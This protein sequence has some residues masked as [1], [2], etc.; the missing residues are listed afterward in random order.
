MKDHYKMIL[1]LGLGMILGSA[2]YPTVM[3]VLVITG[4]MLLAFKL[5]EE[6]TK[7]DRWKNRPRHY[8]VWEH[9]ER[10]DPDTDISVRSFTTKAG[11]KAWS[12]IKGRE[13]YVL[14]ILPRSTAEEAVIVDIMNP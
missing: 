9:C 6:S 11:A 8:D 1:M 2:L 3:A 13:G 12:S 7:N 10:T 5:K 4:L 14:Y